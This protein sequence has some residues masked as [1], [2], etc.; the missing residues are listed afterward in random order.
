VVIT[1]GPSHRYAPRRGFIFTLGR[2]DIGHRQKNFHADQRPPI[3]EHDATLRT[4][5]IAIL[6]RV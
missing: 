4:A 3:D 2:V 6:M 5:E 1:A